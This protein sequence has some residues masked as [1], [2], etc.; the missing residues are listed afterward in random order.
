MKQKHFIDSHKGATPL[1]VLGVMAAYGVWDSATLWVYLALHGTYGLLWVFKSRVFPDRQWEQ[2]TPLWYGLVIW[3]ALTLYWATPVLIAH[4]AV[5]LPPYVLAATVSVFAI[6][7]LFHFGADLQKHAHLSAGGGLLTDGLW[8]RTRNPNYLGELLIYASF[9]A[10]G[11]PWAWVPGI[12][13]AL[14]LAVVW[15]PNMRKKDASLSRYPG[16][17]EWKA[18]SGLLLPRIG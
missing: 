18:G 6:G 13:L 5:A 15:L 14:F 17:A 12:V 3:G 4:F 1:F 2:P 16:F 7:V 10:L 11:G 9:A 8:R